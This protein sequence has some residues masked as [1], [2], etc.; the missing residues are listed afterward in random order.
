MTVQQI[1]KHV[2]PSYVLPVLFVLLTQITIYI[3]MAPRGLDFTDESF[4]LHNYVH[5]REFVGTV[6]FFGAY[7]EWPFKAVGSSVAAIR[8]V[9]L[10]LVLASTAVLM[11]EILHLCFEKEM[12]EHRSEISKKNL[13]WYLIPPMASTLVPFGG[14]STLRAPSYNT[15]ALCTA[16]LL[17]ACLFRFLRIRH[18]GKSSSVVPFL[19]GLLLGVCF[20]SKATT[21]AVVVL[22]HL[23]FIFFAHRARGWSWLPHAA[24]L[25]SAGFLLNLIWLTASFPDWFSSL[26]EGIVL[27]NLRDTRFGIVTQVDALRWE[28]QW[29]LIRI[30]PWF[31]FA[32]LVIHIFRKRLT[33]PGIFPSLLAIGLSSL[34]PLA[35]AGH[36][37]GKLWLVTAAASTTGLWVLENLARKDQH[38]SYDKRQEIAL[39]LLLFLLPIAFSFGTNN[40]ILSH[41]TLAV[42]F[43]SSVI[44]LRLYR[45]ADT[46][47]LPRAVIAICLVL[48]SL[49]ASLAQWR[50]WT[51]I[52]YTYRQLTPLQEQ[53]TPVI[54][55]ADG[56]VLSLDQSTARALDGAMTTAKQVGLLPG[57]SMLDMSGEFPGVV[58]ALG[59]KPLGLPWM[60]GGYPGSD[61]AA[62]RMIQVL[63]ASRVRQAWVLSSRDYPM[64]IKDWRGILERKLGPSSHELVA[65]FDFVN[66][67]GARPREPRTFNLQLWKPKAAPAQGAG[68]DEDV[69]R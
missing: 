30:G 33:Q 22:L 21:A 31:I 29:S 45:I 34:T 16:A 48:T 7:F 41:S 40:S 66:P 54:V 37:N 2:A 17:T 57:H 9:A 65:S 6:T 26:R 55:G 61:T 42:L 19:Y 13:Y 50:S 39:M 69:I 35:L 62:E 63:D 10:V 56:A 1:K 20:L 58:Y 23:A 12:S 52:G 28:I 64:R 43:V 15:L 46:R 47:L 27:M 67:H 38:S 3:W 18:S 24:V 4:Y 32:G 36:V 53:N 49:P 5:W 11:H 25:V 59:A 14:L 51:H 68:T 44:Y 60:L 8:I